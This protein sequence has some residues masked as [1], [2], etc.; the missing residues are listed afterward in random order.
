MKNGLIYILAFLAFFVFGCSSSKKTEASAIGGK[1]KEISITSLSNESRVGA[2]R[3]FF[4][5]Q[6][7]KIIG[8]TAEA[9]DLFKQSI[10]LNPFLDASYFE[11]A[12]IELSRSNY[13]GAENLVKEALNVDNENV[14]YQEFYG[15]ILAAQYKFAEAALAFNALKKQ[16]PQKIDYYLKEAFFLTRDNQFKPALDVYNDLESKIGLQENI[17]VER[18]KIYIKQNKLEEAANEIQKLIDQFPGEPDYSNMLAD[19]YAIN[20]KQDEA[21]ALYLK[22]MEDYPDDAMAITSLADYYKSIGDNENYYK[23][24]RMA[25]GSYKIPIDAKISVLYNHIQFFEEN[26]SHREDAFDLA[27]ILIET[28]PDE[29]KAYA[30]A[31]DLRNLNNEPQKALVFYEQALSIR[32]D[33]YSVWQQVFFILG[34]EKDYAALIAKTNE[35][36]EY[37]PN[38]PTIYYFNGVAHQQNEAYESAIK[39][40]ERGVKM[41]MD[42][43]VLKAQFY[44]N[45]GDVY[46][47]L[48]KY[49]DSDKNFDEAL[50]LEPTNAYV[51]NNYSYY[52]SLR[53][54]NLEKAASMAKL[55]NEIEKNNASFL[56]TY[57][58]VLYQQADYNK[59]LEYQEKAIAVS[60]SP[61]PTLF[62]HLGDILYQLGRKEE[63]VSYW[64]Q[65]KD[66]GSKSENL[67]KK[68]SDK[69]LY[70]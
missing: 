5:A 22:I 17:A 18:H 26:K 2:E 11:L 61:S 10:K 36:K 21:V 24:S 9:Q 33:I 23:Y 41:T 55:A 6:K 67:S 1:N 65:A 56:D 47:S 66:A 30:I 4:D 62:E 49:S 58:W 51:L 60:E 37:F 20:G 14:Y 53:K 42:N 34:D 3:L 68:I 46:N 50:L 70:E 31:G 54:E 13:L 12:Q 7:E 52:L 48:E 39:A 28:H 19:F 59:A 43:T 40:Y 45:L 64:Q 15:D 69:T 8:N 35:A 25:F 29:A 63:A 44:S 16:Y 27:D 38:Q 32:K 57:A